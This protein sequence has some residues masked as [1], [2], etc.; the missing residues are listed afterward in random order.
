MWLSKPDDASSRRTAKLT[1]QH[2]TPDVR[3]GMFVRS[4]VQRETGTCK[5]G[6][7]IVEP[8]VARMGTMLEFQFDNP[9]EVPIYGTGLCIIPPSINVIG[10]MTQ[11]T[12]RLLIR[13]HVQALAVLF[14][15]DGFRALFGIPASIFVN[16]AIEGHSV[17]GPGVTR[18]FEQLGNTNAFAG[19]VTLLDSFL[20]KRLAA[21]Q[22]LGRIHRA[23][24]S[25]IETGNQA[26]VADVA[27]QAGITIR[28]LERKS[29][30]Y[31]GVS[32]KLLVRIARFQRALRMKSSGSASWSEIAHNL[33]Y[34]DQMHMIRDFC[35]FAGE[36]P[37]RALEQTAPDHLIHL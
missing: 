31:A 14:Q 19:R 18:L 36:A 8:V 30:D 26:R 35:A 32:P 7:E 11:R 12:Y 2:A 22:P 16:T 15:P 21:T 33:D 4:Y 5:P 37:V 20:L 17:L 1:V 28:Q 13:D 24:T 6:E 34:Y 25:L 29:L 23:L 9:Y 27:R 3:L 10:P